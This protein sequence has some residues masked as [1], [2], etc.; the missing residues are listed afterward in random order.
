MQRLR[1]EFSRGEEIKFLSHLDL[2]RLWER[3]FRRAGLS[4][5]YSGGFSP[6]PRISLASPLPV[7]ITSQAELMDVF[8]S[9][10][11]S[12]YDFIDHLKP[13]LPKGLIL[14]DAWSVGLSEPSL[15][16]K[17][18][19]AEYEVEVAVE[20][21]AGTIESKLESFLAA[22]KI[23]WQHF[24]DT[25]V[26]NYDLRLLVEDLWLIKCH[27]SLCVLGMRLRCGSSGT[28]RPE[29]V[30]KALDLSQRPKRIHRTGLI[31][32]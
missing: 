16:S 22:D 7:G 25:G 18:T 14:L 5:V 32:N 11:I 20:V 19:F 29:Q 10:W 2:M 31:L 23:P 17:V 12:P 30:T 15:Q 3:A 4:L 6:H 8:L 27:D 24:R 21:E 1:V 9:D 28:G 13:Q 26:R